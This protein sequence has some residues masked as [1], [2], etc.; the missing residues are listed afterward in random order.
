MTILRADF[1][2]PYHIFDGPLVE[3]TVLGEPVGQGAIT[4][5]GHHRTTH[6]N[7]KTLAPWRATIA[8]TLHH[9]AQT[10]RLQLP[11]TGPLLVNLVFVRR[12]PS[13]APKRK[14]SWPITRPDL[15]HY[16]RA[17]LDAGTQAGLWTDDAQVVA[18]ISSKAYP[19][20]SRTTPATPGV[21]IAV[22]RVLEEQPWALPYPPI[23]SLA[24][25]EEEPS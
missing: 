16:E 11:V 1:W 7:H 4:N 6:T 14:T 5:Y 24:V 18:L 3:T 17:V 25:L 2:L 8:A 19:G 21:Y 12:K 23:G 9:D 10:R 15:D 13:S 20:T 22:Y